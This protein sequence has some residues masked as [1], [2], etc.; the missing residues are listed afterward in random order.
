MLVGAASDG[1]RLAGM[2]VE[3]SMYIVMA[4]MVAGLG[5]ATYGLIPERALRAP[6]GVG[7]E[8]AALDTA[9]IGRAHLTLIAAL[10]VALV[11]DVM[12]PA[13]LGF[14]LQAPASSTA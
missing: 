11:V 1:Y 7:P 14:V 2:A 8:A 13:S 5:A 9:P 3:P 4:L 10:I 6:G 12:K